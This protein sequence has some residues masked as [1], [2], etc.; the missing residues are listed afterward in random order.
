MKAVLRV[1]GK[2]VGLNPF[3]ETFLGNV[4]EAILRSLK[5]TQDA[6]SA[7]FQIE[8]K[9]VKLHVDDRPVD[10]HMDRGFAG[11]LVRDTLLGALAHLRGMRGWSQIILEVGL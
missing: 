6:R 4:C 2:L 8:G 3:V 5:G 1:D 7:V 9:K 10:L 11:V